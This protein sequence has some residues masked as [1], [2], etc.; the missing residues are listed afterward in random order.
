MIDDHGYIQHATSRNSRET[1]DW[2]ADSLGKIAQKVECTEQKNGKRE[3]IL[4]EKAYKTGFYVEKIVSL[5]T[6][7]QFSTFVTN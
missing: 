7:L 5:H 2:Q 6:P 3:P 1:A 4:L